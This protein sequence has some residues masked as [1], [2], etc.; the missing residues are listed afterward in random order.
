MT[1]E[2][3][4]KKDIELENEYIRVQKEKMELDIANEKKPNWEKYWKPEIPKWIPALIIAGTT[5]FF[6]IWS[7]VFIARKQEVQNER[8]KLQMLIMKTEIDK[9]I[10]ESQ[11][12]KQEL[13]TDIARLK[14][15]IETLG[16]F[17]TIEESNKRKLSATLLDT[18]LRLEEEISFTPHQINLAS[19]RKKNSFYNDYISNLIES[20]KEAKGRLS[21]RIIDSLKK[22]AKQPEYRVLV[23]YV[24]YRATQENQYFNN[25][26]E[27]LDDV[28]TRQSKGND[29]VYRYD[30][31]F[32]QKKYGF[33]YDLYYIFTSY[34]W[35]KKERIEILNTIWDKFKVVFI[36]NDENI[37][38]LHICTTLYAN[39]GVNMIDENPGAFFT[40]L[41]IHLELIQ[42][43]PRLNKIIGTPSGIPTIYKYPTNDQMASLNWSYY[44]KRFYFV[45]NFVSQGLSTL[46]PQSYLAYTS[47]LSSEIFTDFLRY[48]EIEK[49]LIQKL[50]Q[51]FNYE[52]T[53]EPTK[54][55][56]QDIFMH[57]TRKLGPKWNLMFEGD[58]KLNS[59]SD[60]LN[61][62]QIFKEI[63]TKYKNEFNIWLNP[64]QNQYNREY[65]LTK[66]K[67]LDF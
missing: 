31:A 3:K 33:E 63:S 25:L 20:T 4:P 58:Y 21:A 66:I 53:V 6:T 37:R 22:T 49:S 61:M 52:N 29:E 7:N 39:E 65:I 2:Q 19:L 13:N 45:L 41:Q 10:T 47:K 54:N 26:L 57:N 9:E 27:M 62:T 64:A 50:I 67:T 36:N 14:D 55:K 43:G 8:D 11:K 44:S 42:E 32:N 51:A 15:S 38:L 5:I 18:R 1:G 30:S 48:S 24:L 34:Q 56:L 17:I 60:V 28:V 35:K 46:S 23:N 59:L 16:S 12:V 40:W